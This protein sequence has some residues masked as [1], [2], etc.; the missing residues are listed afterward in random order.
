MLS[1]DKRDTLIIHVNLNDIMNGIYRDDLILQIGR[2]G[3]PNINA[4]WQFPVFIST[5][6]CRPCDAIMWIWAWYKFCQCILHLIIT[7]VDI[8]LWN[9]CKYI[10]WSLFFICSM[11][12]TEFPPR[13]YTECKN[14]VCLCW[15]YIFNENSS[16]GLLRNSG[17]LV[18]WSF[19]PRQQPWKVWK[20]L[21]RHG[22]FLK[23]IKLKQ[24]IFFGLYVERDYKKRQKGLQSVTEW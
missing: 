16:S 7:D 18:L 3:L 12:R 13:T 15:I 11:G 22:K 6:A 20:V 9:T 10:I 2:V 1:E 23:V 24:K 5:T 8:C 14:Q 17:I 4:F 21:N 19:F